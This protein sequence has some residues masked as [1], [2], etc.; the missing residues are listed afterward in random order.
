M[1]TR[2]IG[3]R[4]ALFERITNV[5]MP[6]KSKYDYYRRMYREDIVERLEAAR[7]CFAAIGP[8]KTDKERQE[9]QQNAT[10]LLTVVEHKIKQLLT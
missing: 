8:A 5:K 7:E 4:I 9:F 6:R 10:L 3:Q 2:E 1:N